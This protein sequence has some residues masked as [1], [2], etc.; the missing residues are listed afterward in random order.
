MD[1]LLEPKIIEDDE[2]SLAS[3]SSSSSWSLR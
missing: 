2:Q 1:A 3:P